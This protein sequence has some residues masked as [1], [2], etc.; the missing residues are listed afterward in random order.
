MKTLAL[1]GGD[2]MLGPGGFQTVSGA[3][4]VQLELSLD[5]GER[6]GTDRFHPTEWG[7]TV[8]DY[9]GE[10]IDADGTLAFE[11]QSEVSRMIQ[12]YIAIQQAEIMSDYLNGSRSQYATSDVI[13]GVTSITVVQNVDTFNITVNVTTAAGQQVTLNRT[14]S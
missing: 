6:Y 12:E 7:S 2:L 13:Q 3:S 14:V 11:V 10:P 8:A 9:I 5:L 1:S 4:K